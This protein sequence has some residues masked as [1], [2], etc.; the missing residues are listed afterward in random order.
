MVYVRNRW[1]PATTEAINNFLNLPNNLPN[2]HNLISTLKEQD[3]NVIKDHL[4]KPNTE[5]NHGRNPH[6][7]PRIHLLPEAKLWNTFV[8]RNVMPTSHNQTVDRTRQVLINAIIIGTPF[9][10]GQII[11]EKLNEACKTNQAILAFPCLI[12]ALCSAADVPT[13]LND[14]YTPFRTIWTRKEYMKKMVVMD[15]IPIQVAMP[16][17]PASEQAEPSVPAEAQPSLAATP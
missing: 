15:A 7:V 2:I 8:K 11:L 1:V 14:K 16:T 17:P 13:R 12:T 4:C 6:T 3:Y 9:N 10:I 5:W